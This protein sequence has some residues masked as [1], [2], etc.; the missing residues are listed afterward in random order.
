MR[1]HSI[2]IGLGLASL[3][4]GP[5]A[6]QQG[7]TVNPVPGSVWTYLG[8]TIGADWVAIPATGSS[9]QNANLVYA[10]PGS[11]AASV[12]TF[13]ALVLSD[14][15]AGLMLG[16]SP[17]VVNDVMLW[18]N[19]SGTLA[20]SGP[21]A[22]RHVGPVPSGDWSATFVDALRV[23][24]N[25][26]PPSGEFG[27][28]PP[29][30]VNLA[31]AIVGS[32]NVPSGAFS[33]QGAASFGVAGYG[34]SASTS[35][36]SVGTG[37]F[38]QAV[39]ASA[40]AWGL[41]SAVTNSPYTAP[42]VLGSGNDFGTLWGAEI[43]VNVMKKAG[44]AAPTGSVRGVSIVGNSEVAPSPSPSGYFA[45]VVGPF[46]NVFT[47]PRIPW[48]VALVTED[49]AA[50]TGLSLG[51]VGMPNT[52]SDSQPLAFQSYN[53]GA[54]AQTATIW[55]KS[56]GSLMYNSYT[57]AIHEFQVAT[58]AKAQVAPTNFTLLPQTTANNQPSLIFNLQSRTAA[59]ATVTGAIT[60][61]AAGLL[62]MSGPIGV[63][64]QIGANNIVTLDPAPASTN[65]AINVLV[66]NNAGANVVNFKLSPV[67]SCGAGFRCVRVAN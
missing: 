59:G 15:P 36:G 52:T 2:Y 65:T 49:Q 4:A 47:P 3:A 56:N 44:G 60:Q 45:L 29:G 22:A 30:G 46:G 55:E 37:G 35:Y 20:K 40:N 28:A 41:N 6:A 13:R 67:D 42:Q 24:I 26:F 32:I 34:R 58:V 12:P 14:L 10:G 54:T 17:Q 33:P 1:R 18:A 64:L 8:P 43:D 66:N 51:S 19:T 27:Q 39:A 63:N 38:A 48:Q 50:T 21:V 61:S 7:A 31:T 62:A 53:G 57:G 5:A 16:N 11:G 23:D 25:N 9:A